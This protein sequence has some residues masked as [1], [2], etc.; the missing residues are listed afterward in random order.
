LQEVARRIKCFRET[1]SLSS[2]CHSSR[3]PCSTPAK[4]AQPACATV[5][6][7]MILNYHLMH[8]GG[9]SSPGDP[10]AAFYL[11]GLYH[12]HYILAHP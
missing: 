12:L 10:N 4:A 2:P 3:W 5:A 9:E 7:E 11:D 8:P 1:T 6:E